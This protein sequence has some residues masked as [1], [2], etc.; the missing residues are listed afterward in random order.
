MPKKYELTTES[1]ITHVGVTAVYRIKAL[2]DFGTVR[3]GDL[4]GFVQSEANLSHDGNCWIFDKACVWGEAEVYGDAKVLNSAAVYDNAQV[5]GNAEVREKAHVFRDSEVGGNSI[6]RGSC[7]IHEN[8]QVFGKAQV[9]GKAEVR[10]EARV[11]GF[12][13]VCL[14]AH[15]F[16]G[17]FGEGTWTLNQEAVEEYNNNARIASGLQ[18]ITSLS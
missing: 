5:Y 14:A 8:A 11:F 15:L 6:V 17:D 1:R 9:Y 16:Q 13:K 7:R 18:P 3:A 12:T 10:G 2:R 4:G